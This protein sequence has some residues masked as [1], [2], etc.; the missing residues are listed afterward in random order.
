M[1]RKHGQIGSF[2]GDEVRLS[3][4]LKTKTKER[5]RDGARHG[6][7]KKEGGGVEVCACSIPSCEDS[8]LATAGNWAC[9]ECEPRVPL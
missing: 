2:G 4:N 8:F 3:L 1:D 7:G 5:E 9:P 6:R